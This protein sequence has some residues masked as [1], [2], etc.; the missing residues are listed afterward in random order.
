MYNAVGFSI[1]TEFFNQHH[2]LMLECFNHMR[3]KSQQPLIIP[4]PSLQ[5]QEPL[6]NLLPVQVCRF[7]NFHINEMIQYMVFEDLLFSLKVASMQHILVFH[8]FQWPNNIPLNVLI[9]TTFVSHSLVDGHWGCFHYLTPTNNAAVNIHVQVFVWTLWFISLG[10]IPRVELLGSMINL[11][12]TF[13]GTCRLFSDHPLKKK[14]KQPS[15]FC[16]SK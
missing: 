10:Q 6:I 5:P 3:K 11:C 16:Y 7:W 13:Q 8:S 14:K 1:F 9:Y 2:N 15:S 4:Y 12:L